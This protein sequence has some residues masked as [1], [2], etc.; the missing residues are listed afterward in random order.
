MNED[1]LKKLEKEFYNKLN[2][3]IPY[4]NRKEKV[5]QKEKEK[6]KEIYNRLYNICREISKEHPKKA[7]EIWNK[8]DFHK[9]DWNNIYKEKEKKK[10]KIRKSKIEDLMYS[11]YE[12][13]TCIIEYNYAPK[14]NR[15][16]KE[17]MTEITKYIDNFETLSNFYS[18]YLGENLKEKIKK[19][20][21]VIKNNRNNYEKIK[22]KKYNID[23]NF[24]RKLDDLKELYKLYVITGDYKKEMINKKIEELNKYKNFEFLLEDRFNLNKKQILE[25]I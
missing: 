11:L 12:G 6:N 2:Q 9:K 4:L 23:K 8:T 17:V 10:Q 16:T 20:N 21:N 19:T 22:F 15:K 18:Y 3:Y 13:L 25:N 1:K 7:N 5:S 14:W 24:E